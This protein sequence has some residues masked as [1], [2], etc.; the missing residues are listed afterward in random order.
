MAIKLTKEYLQ[1]EY[2]TNKKSIID[3]GKETSY[4]PSNISYWLRKFEIPRRCKFKKFKEG[5]WNKGLTSETS[6]LVAKNTKSRMKCLG[7]RE[8]HRRLARKS[9]EMIYKTSWK[10]MNLP[11]D[12]VIHHIDNNTMNNGFDNLCVMTRSD[13]TKLH[14]MQGDIHW[15]GD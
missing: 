14:H 11:E 2:L 3:I 5:T 4:T 13:H 12:P 8:H 7:T 15:R 9:L 1:L 10:K 6:K